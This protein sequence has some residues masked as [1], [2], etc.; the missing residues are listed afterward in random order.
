MPGYNWEAGEGYEPFKGSQLLIKLPR[1]FPYLFN[2]AAH[3]QNKIAPGRPLRPRSP[4][5]RFLI[6]LYCVQLSDRMPLVT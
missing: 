3:R 5:P 4:N 2:F 6:T 1:S